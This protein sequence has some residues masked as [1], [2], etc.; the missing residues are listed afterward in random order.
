[1]A[2]RRSPTFVVLA[3]AG[4]LLVGCSAAPSEPVPTPTTADLSTYDPADHGNGVALLPPAD[5]RSSVLT[6]MRA[7]GGGDV[8]GS[9]RDAATGREMRVHRIGTEQSWTAEITLDGAATSI[10]VDAG[11]AWANPSPAVAGLLGLPAGQ[12]SCVS[13]EDPAVER[14]MPLVQPVDLVTQLTT[15]ASGL[16]APAEGTVDLLLG[17]EGAAGVLTV[18]TSGPPLPTRL[19][20]ADETGAVDLT[21]SAWGAEADVTAPV[22]C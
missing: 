11:S 2:E 20:R 1:M 21:F 17:E 14:W 3:L 4:A 16:G 19:V 13:P 12:W 18:A 15:D 10:V 6:A 9:Y 22:A 7:A 8:T 5:A